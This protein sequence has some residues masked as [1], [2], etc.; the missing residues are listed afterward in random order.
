MRRYILT[1][2]LRDYDGYEVVEA[3]PYADASACAKAI[4]EHISGFA[5]RWFD[6]ERALE[7]GHREGGPEYFGILP[8]RWM[9]SWRDGSGEPG[10]QSEIQRRA[11]FL[12]EVERALVS[13]DSEVV[14]EA[15]QAYHGYGNELRITAVALDV[16]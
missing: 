8:E 1:A 5:E 7:A 4:L 10:E 16:F 15:F 13:G 2:V 11:H 14:M 12:S 3:K 6:A 9:F